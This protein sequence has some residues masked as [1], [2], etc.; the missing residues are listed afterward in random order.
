MNYKMKPGSRE[1]DTIGSFR[2]DSI[3]NKI[4]KEIKKGAKFLHPISGRFGAL[5]KGKMIK[6]HLVSLKKKKALKNINKI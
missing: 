3:V 5:R 6:N 2:G 1:N 4:V